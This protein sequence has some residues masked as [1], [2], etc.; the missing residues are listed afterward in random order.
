MAFLAAGTSGDDIVTHLL[1]L[2]PPLASE[3][4]QAP[5]RILRGREIVRS[6][7]QGAVQLLRP[8]VRGRLDLFRRQQDHGARDVGA[9]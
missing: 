4:V 3:G 1:G 6:L 9:L 5:Q 8:R 2:F 7:P